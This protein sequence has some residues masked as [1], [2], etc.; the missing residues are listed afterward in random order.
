MYLFRSKKNFIILVFNLHLNLNYVSSIYISTLIAT[1]AL[2]DL[3]DVNRQSQDCPVYVIILIFEQLITIL[4]IK[5][6]NSCSKN[7]K[8][9]N[10]R[11]KVTFLRY[12]IYSRFQ[13]HPSVLITINFHFTS[14]KNEFEFDISF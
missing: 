1:V 7:M 10:D 5:I 4:S 6:I 13:F 14:S 12:C 9:K 3:F 11:F 2:I 8:K